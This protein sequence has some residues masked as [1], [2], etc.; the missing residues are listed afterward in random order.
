MNRFA[1]L[2]ISASLCF[3]AP[4]G[5]DDS[6]ARWNRFSL[7]NKCEP[8]DLTAR[9]T[10]D[11]AKIGL[12]KEAVLATVRSRLRAARL[13]SDRASAMLLVRI[14]V[15]DPAFH[16]VDI[17]YHKLMTDLAS[18]ETNRAKTWDTGTAGTHGRDSSV[19]LSVVSQHMDRFIDEYLRVNASACKS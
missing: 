5:A 16:V 12:T 11:A 4:A 2:L 3:G 13:Y 8:L 9:M 15:G 7:W 17:S 14:T 6:K 18:G 1:I 19:I 10:G